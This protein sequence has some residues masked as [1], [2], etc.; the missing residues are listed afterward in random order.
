MKKVILFVLFAFCSTMMLAQTITVKGTVIGAE[1][2]MPVIG[3]YVL[4]QGTNNGTSTDVDGNYAIEVPK[5]AT[6]VFSSIGFTTQ[7]V[8]VNGRAQLDIMLKADAVQLD[9]TIVV[10]YGTAKK[11]TY[12]GAASLVKADAIKDA[13]SVSFESA[14][15]GKVAGLQITQSSGQAGSASEIRIRGIGSM[16]A[17]NEPL[18]VIDGVPVTSGD[19]GQASSYTYS[20]NNVMSTLNPSDIESI[21][22]LKDAAASSLYGSRAANGVVMITTKR[23]KAGK[24]TITFKASVGI[25]PSFATDNY[26]VGGTIDNMAY[27]YEVFHDIGGDTDAERNAYALKT[28][29]NKFNKHGYQISTEGTGRYDKINITP[30]Q[31]ANAEEQERLKERVNFFDWEDALLK[32]AVFQTYDLSVSGGSEKTT[33]Y[34]SV[35]YTQDKSR[36]SENTFRRISARVNLNQ[37][38]GNV[39]ELATNFNIA[40]TDRS[41][42]NDT[43]NMGSNYYLATRNL[44]WGVY[45][46]TDYKTGKPWTERYGSYAYNPLYYTN[47]W[48]NSSETFKFQG[49]ETLTAHITEDLTAKTIFSYDYTDTKDHIYYSANHFNGSSD[50]GK[51]HEMSTGSYKVVSSS[52]LNYVKDL[53]EKHSINLLAGFEA[54]KNETKFQRST[55]TNLPS[56]SIPTVATAGVLDASAYSWGNS[57]VSVLSKAEYNYDG[58]YYISGSF[59]RDGSSRLSEDARWGNFWSVAGSWKINNEEFMKGID[60][61]SNLRI[62]ASYGINGTL[63][64]GNYGWRSLASFGSPYNENPGALLSTVADANL[65]WETSYNTNIAVE[66]GFWDQRLYTTIE[67]F[68]RDSKDLLQD[69]PISTVTGFSSTLKNVGE[70][71]NKGLEIEVGG[72]IIRTKDLTWDASITATMMKSEVTKLYDDQD[73]RW[74]DPTGGDSRAQYIYREGESMLALF[75]YEWA[76][77]DPQ[78]G[79]NWYYSNNNNSD[80]QLN[81]RNIVYD[82]NDATEVIIGDVTPKVYGGLNTSVSWKGLTV[83]LNFIY[84]IGGK[85]YDGAQRDIN[86]DGYYWERIRSQYAIDNR[87]K[88]PGDK[89]LVPLVRGTDLDDAMETSTRM[90]YDASFLRLKTLSVSYNIPKE[91]VKKAGLGSARV[92]FSGTNLLTWSNYTMADPEVNAYGTRGWETPYGKTY[93]FGLELSF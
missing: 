63:P 69:V 24:P 26:E 62:R 38:I 11:G 88:N 43:R 92:Y 23:G 39:F 20:T 54:E 86:D 80:T 48:D 16:N 35:S 29:N 25:T 57:M 31:G 50:K 85:L 53:G 2:G 81:G 10:A 44:L 61:I 78:T 1:D 7:A 6:L 66:G 89:T 64:S 30:V 87:W 93:T 14:L 84:K 4:Q 12:T 56:S 15:N 27:L 65:S 40:R 49:S 41:G 9:E 68:N 22:V 82:Y 75:G 74:W 71:N 32:T 17:S 90:M 13:P 36:V 59:R 55:G 52:T 45:W 72:D 42:F 5:D 91:W 8:A 60:W 28:L 73:I 47:E 83:G 77:V 79:R 70:V 33:Y 37:K 58:R 34:S 67:F 76:G 3:A 21:T 18:Y 51:V 19:I 46:P